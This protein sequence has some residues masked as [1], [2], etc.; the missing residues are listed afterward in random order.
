MLW[1]DHALGAYGE[2]S[3]G[4]G[5]PVCRCRDRSYQRCL[6]LRYPGWAAST[7]MPLS[8]NIRICLSRAVACSP[9]QGIRSHV[10]RVINS[11]PAAVIWQW[12]TCML[13]LLA[14][15]LQARPGSSSQTSGSG[16]H[17]YRPRHSFLVSK[18]A[19]HPSTAVR[20]PSQPAR[21]T[22]LKCHTSA[23][24]C[25]CQRPCARPSS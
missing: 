5:L 15:Q 19:A 4:P 25:A 11:N 12:C 6:S 9:L 24:R 8:A 14:T 20:S 21:C 13:L 7:S 1:V 17:T 22:A 2:R 18:P 16:S 10:P 3:P 23:G